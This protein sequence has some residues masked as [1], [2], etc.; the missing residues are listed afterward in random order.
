LLLGCRSTLF[1]G[2]SASFGRLGVDLSI[3]NPLL[4]VGE[5]AFTLDGFSKSGQQQTLALAQVVRQK[6]GVTHH[7]YRCSDF[8]P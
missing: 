4:C 6:V 8:C 7:A 2:D 1:R 3:G 5:S